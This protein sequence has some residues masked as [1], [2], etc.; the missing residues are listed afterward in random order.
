MFR[1]D[2]HCHTTCSDGTLTP[3]ELLLLAKEIGLSGISI[4]DHD[5]IA[6]YTVASQIAQE[7]G[8]KLGSGIE[9]SSLF[10]ALSVHILGYD[11]DLKSPAIQ[12]LCD[13]HQKRRRDR[14]KRILEKLSRLSMQIPEEELLSMQE[15]TVGRPHIA[16]LMVQKGYVSTIK[17]AF[18]LYIGDGRPCFDPG[19]EISSEETIDAI[20]QGGG[21]AFIAHPHFLKHTGKIKELLKLP[22][23]GIECHYARFSSDEGKWWTKTVKEKGWLMSGG[24]DFHGSTKEY[25]P[26]GCSWVDEETFHRIF[27]KLL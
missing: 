23:D 1:A 13:R 11:F 8:L 22:F 7:L 14:N 17:Q 25:I 6:A 2:L 15:G 9:F 3:K 26:L 24:S 4:T 10:R 12:K 5:T 20:H 16:K 27:Q 21:K 18:H 19:E